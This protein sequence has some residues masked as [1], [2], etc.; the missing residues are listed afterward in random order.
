MMHTFHVNSIQ[1][2]VARQPSFCSSRVPAH[3][4]TAPIHSREP[5]HNSHTASN[6]HMPESSSTTAA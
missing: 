3:N 4:K 2:Y 6:R 1:T 5:R